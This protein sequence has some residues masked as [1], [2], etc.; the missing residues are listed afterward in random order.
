[1]RRWGYGIN[2]L[3]KKAHIHVDDAPWWVFALDDLVSRQ[4]NN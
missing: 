1:M 2:S 4:A 3:H